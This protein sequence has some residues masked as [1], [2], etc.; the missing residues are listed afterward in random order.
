MNANEDDLLQRITRDLS[1][2]PAEESSETAT[3]TSWQARNNLAGLN[4]PADD[5]DADGH[6]NL[7]EYA[8]AGQ[9]PTVANATI[10]T[11]FGWTDYDMYVVGDLPAPEDM[12]RID[13]CAEQLARLPAALQTLQFIVA[14]RRRPR[15]PR[16][17]AR[18]RAARPPRPTRTR[19][20]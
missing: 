19:R 7:L 17:R 3:F 13:A 15:R 20:P 8:I 12:I 16:P 2:A 9:D 18:W 11:E 6:T 4:H 5:P 14:R 1:P 10:G